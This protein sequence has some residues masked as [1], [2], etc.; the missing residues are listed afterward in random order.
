MQSN[1]QVREEFFPEPRAV[2]AAVAAIAATYAYF[3]IFAQFGFLRAD[4]SRVRTKTPHLIPPW[5]V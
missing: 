4:P 3:L 1:G 5:C 2:I